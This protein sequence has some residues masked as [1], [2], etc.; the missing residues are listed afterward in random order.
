MTSHCGNERQRVHEVNGQKDTRECG[1][2]L[3]SANRIKKTFKSLE[4]IPLVEVSV[5]V[6]MGSPK[7]NHV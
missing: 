6:S 2:K 4:R 7:G 1:H 3:P 5:V